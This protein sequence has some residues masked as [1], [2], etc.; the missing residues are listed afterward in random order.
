MNRI[1]P[2]AYTRTI[3]SRV[4]P[5]VIAKAR[6]IPTA[7]LHEAGGRIGA[8]P[9]ALKPAAPGMHICGPALTVQSPGGDN[10]W[11]HR[12]IDAAAAGDVLVVHVSEVHE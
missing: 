12:A 11:L 10:L 2:K 8:L 5:Q 4:A 3:A 1:D 9:S 7:T 6:D